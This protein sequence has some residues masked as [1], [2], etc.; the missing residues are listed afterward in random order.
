MLYLSPSMPDKLGIHG[1]SVW[2]S[3][4]YKQV[5]QSLSPC[6]IAVVVSSLPCY[7]SVMSILRLCLLGVVVALCYSAYPYM[8][9]NR[10]LMM[11]VASL[12]SLTPWRSYRK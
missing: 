7:D 1:S 5:Q 11:F 6:W 10:N 9:S 12:S 8:P 2:C 4:C 3:F